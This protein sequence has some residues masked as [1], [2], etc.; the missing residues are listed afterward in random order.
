MS[1]LSNG[2]S[3]TMMMGRYYSH[4]PK[5]TVPNT[6]V[7]CRRDYYVE[8]QGDHGQETTDSSYSSFRGDDGNDDDPLL[9]LPCATAAVA[10]S[11]QYGGKIVVTTSS[12][13]RPPP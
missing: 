11:L 7:E 9:P 1:T 2:L 4:R 13:S 12:S 10:E 3:T 8:R 5:K 6:Y